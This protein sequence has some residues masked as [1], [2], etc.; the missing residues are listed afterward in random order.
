MDLLTYFIEGVLTA[1][2][3]YVLLINVLDKDK[4]KLWEPIN[5]ISL[6]YLYYCTMPVFFNEGRYVITSTM[7]PYLCDLGALLS[8][9]C[10][11]WGYNRSTTKE[12]TKWNVLFTSKNCMYL[13]IALFVIGLACYVPFRGFATS[14]SYSEGVGDDYNRD[15][16]TSYFIGMISL[17]CGSCSLVI[18][19][20]KEK[21]NIYSLII[22]WLSFITYIVGGFRFRLVALLFAILIPVY[23]YPKIKKPNYVVLAV[24]AIVA[25]LG[26]AVMDKARVYGQGIDFSK[27]TE[28]SFDD[29][30]KGAQEN[31]AV[32]YYSVLCMDDIEERSDYKFFDPL[33]NAAL[34]PI[35]RF[36]FPWKPKGDYMVSVMKSTLGS[37]DSGAASMM[38]VEAF[39]SFGWIGIIVF[40]YLIGWFSKVVWDN[41]HKNQ[42]SIGAILFLS[43]FDG[44]LYT[45]M[46]RGYL[47]QSFVTYMYYVILPFWFSTLILKMFGKKT[48][49]P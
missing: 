36:L 29:A 44:F 11:I 12:F 23:L 25:Y 16:F 43:L 8:Y 30:S 28:M 27:V 46:S 41:Y 38:F 17:F 37:T 42:G 13:G 26:F 14:I 20:I 24:I 2:C 47:A 22:I 39:L 33:I 19:S 9:L 3:I 1:I 18:M 40:F 35:P 48:N 4:S 5:V 15:G 49:Q 6:V 7:R 45:L 21:K 34:M 32:Y 10:L 31:E